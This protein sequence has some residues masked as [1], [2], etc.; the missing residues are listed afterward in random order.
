M[1]A[2][3]E[4]DFELE[5]AHVLFIDVIG[6]STLPVDDQREVTAE[7]N[8]LVRA[9]AAFRAAEEANKLS[10]LPTGDGMALAF[11]TTP[12]APTRCAVQ[13]AEALRGQS[14]FRVRMGM[15][16]G[17][18]S[19][20]T[21]VNDRSNIAGA[22][23]NIA[24]RV[25]DCGDAGHILL[26]RHIA[27]DLE[28][29]R[30]WRPYLHPLGEFDVKHGVRL[31]IV[32]FHSDEIGNAEIPKKL[33]QVPPSPVITSAPKRLRWPLVWTSIA[34]LAIAVAYFA[35]SGHPSAPSS[36]L[37]SASP[38]AIS[39]KSIAV[40]PFENLSD[41]KQ[42]SY[43][44]DGVQ[45][46]ILTNLS[47][48]SDLKVI[49][50]TSVRQYKSGITRN[51]REI[52]QQLRVA[53]ILEGSVQSAPPN[54]LRISANLIDART[55]SQLWAET[56]DRDVADLFAIQS[57]LA[58]AIANQLQARLSPAQ[59]AE[60]EERPT[61]DLVAFE[62]YLQAKGTIDS[63]IIAEDVRA[64]LL[65]AL[66]ALEQATAQDEQFVLAYC[67]LAR[68][69]SL[70][71][72]F[73]LDPAANRV[74]LA[75]AAAKAALRLRPDSAEAHLA[76]ADYYFRCQ[77]DY[78]RA[79][80]ELAIARPGLPNSTPFFI[81]SGYINRRQNHFPEAEKDFITAVRLDPRNPNAYN[82][83]A[84]TY[85][86]ERRFPLSDEV[87]RNVIAA[88][89]DT[90]IVR[91]RQAATQ[92]FFTGDTSP[93]RE[94]LAKAPAD[95]DVGGGETPTRVLLAILD[96]DYARAEQA[97]AISPRQ[98][99]Q[100]ID[101]S[102]YYPKA[103]YEAMIARAKGDLPA[104]QAAF[105]QVR[106]ILEQRLL[107]KPEHART[108]AVLAQVDAGLGQKELALHEAQHA[109]DLMPLSKDVYD[110]ALVLESF[111]Q[112]CTWTGEHDRAI[113]LLQ[114]LVAI[115]SY[116]NYG[117]LKVHP[118]WIPLRGNPRFEWTVASMAPK[119]PLRK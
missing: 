16:S 49:S 65:K 39:D 47:K 84:D 15:H 73:D 48:V 93:M 46:Q 107:L 50:H 94:V 83:L 66:Q 99:F 92:F 57:E 13:L 102:F 34:L 100:D 36:S 17:P 109:V 118:S 72:F 3:P 119:E 8:R 111:A 101:F 91:Y 86:L 60:I 81:L 45:D 19:G 44:A 33:T 41:N 37:E 116:V 104:A 27:E 6:Y 4:I 52:G 96:H 76:M 108:L 98:D 30:V 18:V 56:Y 9:T 70:L 32:N 90:P 35:F 10:R 115:P 22:G 112:V 14:K 113:E 54:R 28:S 79:Q 42:N 74:L 23:I 85:V 77:R 117:R 40:L 61:H 71:Y 75:E 80:S 63:Y 59:K 21:D 7:L 1:S 97:L 67:Y 78:D 110:G 69:H 38:P 87:S 95:L 43:F 62:L 53:Y 2:Q 64:A 58:Q 12:E 5:I 29:Y 55:D 68:V 31:G 25:M 88:G 106:A 89:D 26:S 20:V 24:Q 105:A 103:W 82:L 51:L 114:K 11:F